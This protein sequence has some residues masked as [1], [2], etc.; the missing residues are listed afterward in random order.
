M[1]CQPGGMHVQVYTAATASVESTSK[2]SPSLQSQ[3]LAVSPLL[4]WLVM[5]DV[6]RK[7]AT[8]NGARQSLAPALRFMCPRDDPAHAVPPSNDSNPPLKNRPCMR[9]ISRGI[10]RPTNRHTRA[11]VANLSMVIMLLACAA[12]GIR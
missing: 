3:R 11:H 8:N 4:D 2:A 5:C 7:S 10:R 12:T 1:V 9:P 6:T